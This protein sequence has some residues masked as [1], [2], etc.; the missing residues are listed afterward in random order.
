[1]K[2]NHHSLSPQFN[3][4]A[5]RHLATSTMIDPYR[6]YGHGAGQQ[7]IRNEARKVLDENPHLETPRERFMRE[8]RQME[9]EVRGA[10]A[11]V[12]TVWR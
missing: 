8:A 10:V 12:R 9:E 3:K 5:A 2:L 4:M 7:L 1:M 11:A 6:R